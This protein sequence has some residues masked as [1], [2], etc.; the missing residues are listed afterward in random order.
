M[1]LLSEGFET[2]ADLDKAIKSIE[3]AVK[4][5]S[6]AGGDGEE[7]VSLRGTVCFLHSVR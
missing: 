6:K 3:S 2:L 7:E 1:A 4:R 5:S